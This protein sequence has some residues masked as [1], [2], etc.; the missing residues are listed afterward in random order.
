MTGNL[1]LTSAHSK[2]LGQGYAHF[3]SKLFG[4]CDW[5]VSNIKVAVKLEVKYGLSINIFAFD[6]DQ[7]IGQGRDQ[8]IMHNFDRE[9]FGNGDRFGS[10]TIAI[11][12]DVTYGILITVF[13]FDLVPF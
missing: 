1:H 9:F 6:L 7:F 3:D 8:L 10:I 2:G 5:Y 4:S 11:K 13:R 12:Q